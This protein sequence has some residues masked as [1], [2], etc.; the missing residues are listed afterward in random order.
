[1][2]LFVT[3]MLAESKTLVDTLYKEKRSIAGLGFT[4]NKIDAYLVIIY[5]IV[6][7][8]VMILYVICMGLR[9][10]RLLHHLERCQ[11]RRIDF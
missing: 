2:S 9:D 10:R 3:E 7:R 1:M 4:Y 8:G 5:S 6:W 11:C